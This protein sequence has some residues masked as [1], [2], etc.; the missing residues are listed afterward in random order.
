MDHMK[1]IKKAI[2]V[3]RRVHFLVEV[4]DSWTGTATFSKG[5]DNIDEAILMAKRKRQA[6]GIMDGPYRA[7]SV[8]YQDTDGPKIMYCSCTEFD[9]VP[10]DWEK[11]KAYMEAS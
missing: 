8:H 4:I 9:L 6:P 1:R 7:C 5:F 10:S 2:K 11:L 3:G